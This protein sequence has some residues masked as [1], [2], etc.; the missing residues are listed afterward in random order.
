M[1]VIVDRLQSGPVDIVGDIHGEITAL[2]HLLQH[3]GYSEEGH[4]PEGRHLVFVGDLC[5]RGED[6]PGVIRRV[7]A[8]VESG[9]AQAVIGNHE[10]NL[11]R[12]ESK[13]GNGWYYDDPSHRDAT[14]RDFKHAP[15]ARDE[16]RE[17]FL[18][19]FASLPVALARDDLRV[20]HAC[21]HQA[22]IRHLPSMP[23]DTAE[24]F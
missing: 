7:K 6:S 4:H 1:P 3:L 18:N 10:L 23:T 8:L 19:F 16:E 2:E 22:S 12:G 24:A 9:S 21:W 5:D 13:H 17:T 11:L 15:K 20:V 14:D